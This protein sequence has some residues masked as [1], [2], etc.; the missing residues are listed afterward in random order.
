MPY[1]IVTLKKGREA[2]LLRRHPWGFS[3][4]VAKVDGTP[5]A[6]ASVLVRSADGADLGIAA[7]SPASQIRLRMWSFDPRVHIDDAFFATRIDKALALREQLFAEGQTDALRLV[8]SEADGLPGFVADQYGDLIVVQFLAAGADAHRETLIR[9]L[10]E[11]FPDAAFYERSDSDARKKEGLDSRTGWIG[12]QKRKLPVAVVEEGLQFSVDVEGGHKTG[13]YLDQRD[14]RVL[15]G[16]MCDG[17]RV[18]NCFSY[19]GGFA[20]HALAGGAGSVVDVDVSGDALTLAMRNVRDNGFDDGRYSQEAADV[21]SYLR[22]CRDARRQFDII[23]LD[24]PK[25][26]ASASQVEKAARGY[27]DINLLA[28]KL[29]REGGQLFTFSCSGHITPP[30]FQKILADAAAD[31]GRDAS[32]LVPLMQAPDHPVALHIPES[33]Y[34]KGWLLGV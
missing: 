26:A 4:A 13:F 6:G 25:F 24:P 31:A 29:L 19:T 1:P 20:L 18:L 10:Q 17:A 16:Q 5:P 14:N 32:L 21:F 30:L 12:E 8:S 28:M 22:Q 11:R 2:S 15:L 9:L 23:V 7:W 27:K 3:G 34:L 33:W